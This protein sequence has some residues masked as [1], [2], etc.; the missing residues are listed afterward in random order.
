MGRG[1]GFRGGGFGGRG[2]GWR[3]MY[4]ATGVPGYARFG[5]YP[6]GYP[7]QPGYPVAIPK[8]DP[9]MEKQA[10]IHHAEALQQQAEW[11][12]SEIESIRKRIQELNKGTPAE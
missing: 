1:R 8:P 9:E 11:L 5:G 7:V 12:Q 2:Y 6:A 3:H 4:Y 10:L